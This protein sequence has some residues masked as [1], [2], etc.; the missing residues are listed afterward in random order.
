MALRTFY[1][2]NAQ[3]VVISLPYINIMMTVSR[4]GVFNVVIVGEMEYRPGIEIPV[5]V[6]IPGSPYI[7]PLIPCDH[8]DAGHI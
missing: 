5:C 8:P 4:V 7:I 1:V 3:I 6:V 2:V